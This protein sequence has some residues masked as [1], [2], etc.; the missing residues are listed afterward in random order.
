[1]LRTVDTQTD[2]GGGYQAITRKRFGVCLSSASASPPPRGVKHSLVM[3]MLQTAL[4]SLGALLEQWCNSAKKA[5]ARGR[6]W[7]FF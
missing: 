1:M 4:L 6:E 7:S 5:S 3:T 2:E